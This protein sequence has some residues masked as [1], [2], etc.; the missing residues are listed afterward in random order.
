MTG[1]MKGRLTAA[2]VVSALG[3]TGCV[4]KGNTTICSPSTSNCSNRTRR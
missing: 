3:L 4:S 2:L 1:A